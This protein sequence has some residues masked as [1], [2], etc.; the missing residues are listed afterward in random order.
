MNSIPHNVTAIDDLPEL[1]DLESQRFNGSHMLPQGE[2]AKFQKFIRGNHTPPP[3]A[4]MNPGPYRPPQRP[5]Q[6]ERNP[7]IQENL[8]VNNPPHQNAPTC[9]EVADHVSNCPICSRFY[10]NDRTMYIITIAVLAIIC[11]LLLKKVLDL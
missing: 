1:E 6:Y 2:A 4:G 8:E 7:Y 9:L 5:P 3:E 10:N 11:I